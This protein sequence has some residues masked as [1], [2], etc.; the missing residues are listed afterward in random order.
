M[1]TDLRN[2]TA[3]GPA[4]LNRR[5]SRVADRTYTVPGG[6]VAYSYIVVGDNIDDEAVDT[7]HIVAESVTAEKIEAGSI[8]AEKIAA[9][10]VIAEKISANAITTVK[11]DA[12]SVTAEKIAAGIIN[13]THIEAGSITTTLLAAEAVTA[14]KIK[15]GTITA[16]QIESKS[17]TADRLT[18]TELSS[19]S[20]NLGEITAGTIIGT[21]IKT[22]AEG[23]R[24]EM[25]TAGLKGINA[26][27]ETKFNFDATTG[28]LTATAVI[29]SETGSEIDTEHLAGQITETQIE[30]D[31]I[32]TPKLKANI[33]EGKHLAVETLGALKADLGTITA[34]TIKSVTIEGVTIKAS[35]TIEGG[36]IKGSTIEGA[37]G[38]FT[39]ELH[40]ESLTL[41]RSGTT[42]GESDSKILWTSTGEPGG[43]L[44]AEIFAYNSNADAL[45][46]RTGKTSG[47]GGSYENLIR[48]LSYPAEEESYIDVHSG[49]FSKVLINSAG[50]SNFVQSGDNLG[51]MFAPKQILLWG[52][53]DTAT[54]NFT[55]GGTGMT[56]E[57]GPTGEATITYSPKFAEGPSIELTCLGAGRVGY[58]GSHNGTST[59]V[60]AQRINS[61]TKEDALLSVTVVGVR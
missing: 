37:E 7:K 26:A 45:M 51:S 61:E 43:S 42:G 36:T 50:G 19:I 11:L 55:T 10:A 18:V 29:S 6:R 3:S 34:G 24:V 15:A 2:T 60:K 4:A 25:T 47:G 27:A 39:G 17:I 20:A 54:G 56:A 9:N 46:M 32:S 21:T 35:S 40:A 1:P 22:A 28:I 53:L 41:P 33:I 8:T 49:G 52:I 16:T 48:S 31:S 57:S 13:A 38:D 59:V 5:V 23:A 30:D 14:E 58:T 12:E 44:S